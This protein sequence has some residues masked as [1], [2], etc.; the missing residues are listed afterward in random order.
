MKEVSRHILHLR[1]LFI[2]TFGQLKYEG[3]NFFV[4]Y[5][6]KQLFTCLEDKNP[7]S[8]TNRGGLACL[9]SESS[10]DFRDQSVFLTLKTCF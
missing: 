6:Y 10:Q 8:S 2:K 9:F 1:K 3:V 5:T 7:E 4:I